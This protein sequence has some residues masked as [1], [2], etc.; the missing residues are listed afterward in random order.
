MIKRFSI[1]GNETLITELRPQ[2]L[3]LDNLFDAKVIIDRHR[4][5]C[6][7]RNLE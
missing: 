3:Y 1:R 4:M 5:R 7:Y 6:C 2:A